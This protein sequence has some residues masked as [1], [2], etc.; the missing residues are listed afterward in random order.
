M[1]CWWCGVAADAE[2]AIETPEM[3][4]PVSVVYCW[5]VGDR[6]HEHAVD[7]PSPSEL[8]DTGMS[9]LLR[10]RGQGLVG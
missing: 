2:Y 5:P 1:R 3:A 7:P 9:A 4:Q 6:E 10:L 8:A